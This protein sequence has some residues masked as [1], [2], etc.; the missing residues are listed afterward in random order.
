[1]HTL[2]IN[3]KDANATWGVALLKGAT[4]ALLTPPPLKAFA[5]QHSRLEDGQRVITHQKKKGEEKPQPLARWDART[6]NIPMFI[7]AKGGED[8][9]AQLSAFIQEIGREPF[10]LQTSAASGQ[11]FR[12]IYQSCS[13]FSHAGGFCKFILKVVEP[14]PFAS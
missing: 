9:T 8:Y 1:M 13:E 10:T 7:Q 4:S 5:T 14:Q 3:N 2:Y 6:L 11:A 12:L